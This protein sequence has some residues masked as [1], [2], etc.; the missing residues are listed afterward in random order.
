[1]RKNRLPRKGTAFCEYTY[2]RH[3]QKKKWNGIWVYVDCDG[4]KKSLNQLLKIEKAHS[5]I[6]KRIIIISKTHNGTLRVSAAK[7]ESESYLILILRNWK[8]QQMHQHEKE[9][10][11]QLAISEMLLQQWWQTAREFRVSN[12]KSRNGKRIFCCCSCQ[13]SSFFDPFSLS[14]TTVA[15]LCIRE[16]DV[17]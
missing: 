6:H 2:A 10:E 4:K 11:Q 3:L 7:K 8:R 13:S 12:G 16:F 14:H 1:M 5:S 15:A 17:E 9:S